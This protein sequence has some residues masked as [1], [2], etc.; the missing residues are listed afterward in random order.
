MALSLK[1]AELEELARSVAEATGETITQ[2]VLDALRERQARLA[3]R[4][5][6]PGRPQRL[7]RF[8]AEEVWPLV[9]EAECGR[10][11]DRVELDALLGYGSDG[12]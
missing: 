8:L 10:T 6:S 5:T 9:P 11:M 4:A 7:A 1:N 3:L 2:T 12:V